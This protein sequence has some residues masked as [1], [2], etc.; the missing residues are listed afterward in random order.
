MKARLFLGGLASILLV[1][2]AP[3]LA[4]FAQPAEVSHEVSVT[5]T[6]ESVDQKGRTVLLR[7]PDGRLV[8]V[9]VGPQV[10]NLAQVKPGDQVGIKYRESLAVAMAKP[11]EGAQMSVSSAMSRAKPG[12]RPGGMGTQTVRVQAKITGVDANRNTV[13]FIGPAGEER[14]VEVADP[15]MK[16]FIRTLKTGDIVDVTYTR[17]VAVAVSTAPK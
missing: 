4:A 7:G 6:V 17:A 13:S 10:R 14:T 11:G 5:A 2:S 12:E 16:A 3:F 8:T 15:Q 9:T 1:G